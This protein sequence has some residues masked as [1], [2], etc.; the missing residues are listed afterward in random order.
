MEGYL[1]QMKQSIQIPFTLFRL[2]LACTIWIAPLSIEGGDQETF[3]LTSDERGESISTILHYESD[4]PSDF[5]VYRGF[6]V[7]YLCDKK[8]PKFTIHKISPNQLSIPEGLLSAKRRSTFFVDDHQA[9]ECSSL[10]FD[11]KG[12]GYDRG[13]L[14]PAGD[15]VW[16]Q[17]LKDETFV[18]SNI[19]PQTANLNRGIWKHL[20]ECIREYSASHKTELIIITGGTYEET[21]SITIGKRGLAVPS[22]TYKIIY[23]PS[24]QTIWCYLFPNDF[25]NFKSIVDYQ[26]S[27]DMIES[28][29]SEDFF[30]LLPDSIEVIL[31]SNLLE[32]FCR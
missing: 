7:K 1:D 13:H 21:G 12:S 6:V 15:F 31:E 27:V 10:P 19:F 32:S 5:W 20:E 25:D 8:V 16:D 9:R 23:S 22:N 14:V 2:I 3:P 30:D 18:Y 17:L 11:Y 29:V 24:D 4:S 26:E 28:L